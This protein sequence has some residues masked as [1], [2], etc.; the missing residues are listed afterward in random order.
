[1]IIAVIIRVKGDDSSAPRHGVSRSDLGPETGGAMLY[2]VDSTGTARPS[3]PA[4]DSRHE[5][6]RWALL[7]AAI[8][9][10]AE[11]GYD[12]V[13]LRDVAAACG[14]TTG[15]IQY[16]FDSRDALLSAAFERAASRQLESWKRAVRDETDE[17]RK[18]P[19][20]LEQML[21]EFSSVD[22]CTVWAELCVGA[23]RHAHLQS[24]VREVFAQWHDL[25]AEA[26]AAGVEH[27]ALAPVLPVDDATAIIIAAVDGF[28]LALATR[29]DI[30]QPGLAVQRVMQLAGALFPP[31]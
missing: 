23:A 1:M 22:T 29:A 14:V 27:G 20:L 6:R 7:E 4:A 21:A 16:H 8:S 25:L 5:I 26:V 12:A 10:I 31:A 24:V 30:A 19:A 2:P 28:E 3:E 9:A 17:A 11:Q 18:L 15:M 13:R